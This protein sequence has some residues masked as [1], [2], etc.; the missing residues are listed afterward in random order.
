MINYLLFDNL[1]ASLLIL[2]GT[3]V[4]VVD[5]EPRDDHELIL[6]CSTRTHIAFAYDIVR[7]P[8]VELK[9]NT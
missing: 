4:R 2:D 6:H 9:T 1:Y 3:T 5:C 8:R 7:L